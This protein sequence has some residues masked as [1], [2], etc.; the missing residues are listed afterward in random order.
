MK[1]M[2]AVMVVV[3]GLGAIGCSRDVGGAGRPQT[4]LVPDVAGLPS[5]EATDALSEAGFFKFVETTAKSAVPA[6]HAVATA[7]PAVTCVPISAI[8]HLQLS[9]GG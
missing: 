9:K 4:A 7:P 6:G 1:R 8:V 3:M 2:V 5:T